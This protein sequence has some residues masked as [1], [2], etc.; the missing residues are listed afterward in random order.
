MKYMAIIDDA[1]LANFRLDDDGLTLVVTDQGGANRAMRLK[2]LQRPVIAMTNGESAYLT[3]GHIDAMIA[4][5]R[6]QIVYELDGI[7]NKM[8][9]FRGGKNCN[10][11]QE[12]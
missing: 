10:G 4:F 1:M 7:T 3:Q 11:I 8:I 5:E 6:S 9:G 12:S 2:P